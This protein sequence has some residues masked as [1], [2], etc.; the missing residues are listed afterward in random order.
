LLIFRALK[1]ISYPR[2][3]N[4]ILK[5]LLLLVFGLFIYLS[6]YAQKGPKEDPIS[7][8]LAISAFNEL[9]Y[10]KKI[11]YLDSINNIALDYTHVD[12]QVSNRSANYALDLSITSNY[13]RGEA[14]AIRTIATIKLLEG[15]YYSS[16]E[17]IFNSL[18]IFE[19]L[20]D[21]EGIAD[22][23]LTLGLIYNKLGRYKEAIDSHQKSYNFYSESENIQKKAISAFN[24]STSH[25]NIEDLELSQSYLDESLSNAKTLKLNLLLGNIYNLKGKLSLTNQK[26]DEALRF[27]NESIKYSEKLGDKSQKD[28]YIDALMA[29]AEIYKSEENYAV[30][31]SNLKQAQYISEKYNFNE[32]L[33]NIY[34]RLIEAFLNNNQIEEAELYLKE[35]NTYKKKLEAKESEEKVK[36][37]FQIIEKGILLEQNQALSDINEEREEKIQIITKTIIIG[38]YCLLAFLIGTIYTIRLLGKSKKNEAQLNAFYENAPMGIVFLDHNFKILKINKTI[39][40]FLDWTSE[41]LLQ[42]NIFEKLNISDKKFSKKI[43]LERYKE[44]KDFVF[45]HTNSKIYDLRMNITEVNINGEVFYI[46]FI[47]DKTLKKSILKKNLELNELLNETYRIAGIGAYEL[48]YRSDKGFTIHSFSEVAKEILGIKSKKVPHSMIEQLIPRNELSKYPNLLEKYTNSNEYFDHELKV[49]H[50]NGTLL[51]LRIIGKIESTIP[52]EIEI[53]GIFQDITQRKLL[54][55]QLEHNLDKEKELNNLK[56]R[57]I[58]MTSHEFKTPLSTI[59]SSSELIEIH[60][61]NLPE[62]SYKEKILIQIQRI[63]KQVSRL[64]NMMNDILMLEKNQANLMDVNLERFKIGSFLNEFANE[65]EYEEDT[66]KLKINVHEKDF[67]VL[68]DKNILYYIVNNLTSNAFK[69]S[70]DCEAPEIHATLHKNH[71]KLLI[72]DFGIGIPKEEQKHVFDSF[73]RGKNVATIKGTGLGLFIVKEFLQRLNG[74]IKFSSQEGKGTTFEIKLPLGLTQKKILELN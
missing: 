37:L 36:N 40:D 52:G 27:I 2:N 28:T 10:P 17:N 13:K 63:F 38:I 46:A 73:F 14:F 50:T 9:A 34:L 18:E 62:S 56:S 67:E 30:E 70:P 64:G 4:Y 71:F 68:M 57:F 1:I 33:N 21:K 43:L 29:K 58:S 42:H 74:Q 39:E 54:I 15:D 72:K 20:K 8:F 35:F 3:Q 22:A 6:S 61:S 31:I 7:D 19:K 69:Y 55:N 24:L 47:E 49:Y 25:F 5:Y 51:Y 26:Q 32:N 23:N 16:M 44:P 45:R 48:Y 66:R 11:Q 41:E 60:V 65:F 53:K 59:N 12:R